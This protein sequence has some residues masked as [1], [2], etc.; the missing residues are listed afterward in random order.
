[1]NAPAGHFSNAP[2]LADNKIL[3]LKF[4]IF[5]LPFFKCQRPFLLLQ[6]CDL[7][8]GVAAEY[9]KYLIL[10]LTYALLLAVSLMYTKILKVAKDHMDQIQVLVVQVMNRF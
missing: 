1:M 7:I 9:W 2:L 8:N 3:V 10:P 6:E 4:K 5:S